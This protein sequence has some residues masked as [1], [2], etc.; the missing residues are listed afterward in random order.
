ME[1]G[2][3]GRGASLTI[4]IWGVHVLRDRVSVKPTLSLCASHH[5]SAGVVN[6][7]RQECIVRVSS[8]P[9]LLQLPSLSRASPRAGS[10]PTAPLFVLKMELPKMVGDL[11]TIH[12]AEVDDPSGHIALIRK[13]VLS[14]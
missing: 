9:V 3:L 14:W 2:R 5:R 12:E 6:L 13:A 1:R 11:L 8:P 7:W 10:P 4:W